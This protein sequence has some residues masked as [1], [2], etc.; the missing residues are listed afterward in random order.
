MFRIKYL[1]GSDDL[2]DADR[3]FLQGFLDSDTFVGRIFKYSLPDVEIPENY[4][5]VLK[6]SMTIS[7]K[8]ESSIS[9]A[10]SFITRK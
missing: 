5:A 7:R 4:L 8:A 2:T 1:L 9:S 6:K 10:L 3:G